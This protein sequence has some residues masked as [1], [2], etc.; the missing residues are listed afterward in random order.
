[1]K[2]IAEPNELS[3]DYELDEQ[4]DLVRKSLDAI[5]NDISMALRDAGLTF[6]V[7]LTVP[8]SGN[9]LASIATAFDPTDD[10]WRHASE[11]ACQI[12]ADRLGCGRLR[13]RELTCAVANGTIAAADVTANRPDPTATRPAATSSTGRVRDAVRTDHAPLRLL[14]QYAA[15]SPMQANPNRTLDE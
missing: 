15:L 9:S 2:N 5:A 11:I 14:Q 1:M 7:F 12:I 6:P 4:R 8:S 13:G 10:D 3:V